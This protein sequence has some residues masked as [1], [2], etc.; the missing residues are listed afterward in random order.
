[1]RRDQTVA[2]APEYH[3]RYPSG[4]KRQVKLQAT[5]E[6]RP[7]KKGEWYISGAIPEGYRAPNDL[8]QAFNIGRLVEVE[9]M[10]I[11]KVIAVIES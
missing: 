8:S 2:L 5:G 11:E 10:T 1:M 4:P 6:Y 3:Y 7:P 9:T